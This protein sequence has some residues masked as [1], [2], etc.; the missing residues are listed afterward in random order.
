M[1]LIELGE[2][3][4]DSIAAGAQSPDSHSLEMLS[5]GSFSD[6]VVGKGRFI[7]K[8]IWCWKA[9]GKR[10]RQEGQEGKS[11][12]VSS[13][14]KNDSVWKKKLFICFFG[15]EFCHIAR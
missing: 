4:A 2:E 14:P 12:G 9:A 10:G 5:V 7:G 15:K 3:R 13:A 8:H 6:S 11:F 1:I